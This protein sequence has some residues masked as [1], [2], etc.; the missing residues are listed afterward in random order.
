M[1]KVIDDKKT[2]NA[3]VRKPNRDDSICERD[4]K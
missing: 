2:K 4:Q 3:T 1:Y